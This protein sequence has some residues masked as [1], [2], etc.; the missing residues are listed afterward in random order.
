MG[1]HQQDPDDQKFSKDISPSEM[2]DQIQPIWAKF[3]N[4][5]EPSL[6]KVR[7]KMD[8]VS[9]ETSVILQRKD[10]PYSQLYLARCVIRENRINLVP[11]QYAFMVSNDNRKR[12]YAVTLFPKEICNCP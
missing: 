4:S 7:S 2:S 1:P 12:K 3:E 8:K 11:A 5:K 6:T 9:S 10:N